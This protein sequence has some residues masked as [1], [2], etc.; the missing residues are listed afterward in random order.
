MRILAIG[1]ICGNC[2]L[3]CVERYLPQVR[4]EL[5]VDAVVANGENAAGTGILPQQAERLFDAGVDVMT[6][7]NHAFRQHSIADY[8]AESSRMIRPA[9]FPAAVP[10]AGMTFFSTAVG[11]LCVINLIGRCDMT[12]GPESPFHMADTLLKKA[13]ERTNFIVVD[14]HAEA[15]SEKIAMAYYLD[16]RAGAVWGTHTHVQTADERIFP[17]GLGFLCDLGMT[18]AADSV[19]GVRAEDS[20]AY[21]CGSMLTRFRPAEGASTMQGALFELDDRTGKCVGVERIRYNED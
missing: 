6:L 14:F 19:L 21:F 10:G 3:S 13:K 8:L 4:R 18:G 20:V 11:E 15:T 1:D 16:G 12:F 2:G 9:N 17:Q 7:G 5:A